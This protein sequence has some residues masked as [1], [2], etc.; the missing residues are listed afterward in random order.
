MF[1]ITTI[2]D[3]LGVAWLLA[4]ANVDDLNVLMAAV[5]HDTVEDTDT[6]YDEIE[7]LFG[8]TVRDIVAECSD[9]KTK[10]KLERKRLQ[11]EHA[12]GSS[13][14]AK[15][16]KLAD[17]LYNL[18]DLDQAAPEGWTQVIHRLTGLSTSEII[19][20][21]FHFHSISGTMWRIF[22]MGQK[23]GW[24]FTRH[25]STTGGCLRQNFYKEKC[26]I[27]T[28]KSNMR[29]VTFLR[30]LIYIHFLPYEGREIII[31]IFCN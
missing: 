25:Q 1:A 8:K 22:P 23:C 3:L 24:Q 10:P 27:A 15:L 26:C 16:V 4:E 20:L 11:I 13:H 30:V 5:L 29:A 31:N 21:H 14:Q 12:K 17:K 28:D 18:R 7:Q 2:F 6:T 9:D 19:S